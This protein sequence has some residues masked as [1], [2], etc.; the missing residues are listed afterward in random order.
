MSRQS[1]V[2]Y[3]QLYCIILR[4]LSH[5]C[6]CAGL[7]GHRKVERVRRGEEGRNV[8]DIMKWYLLS[9]CTKRNPHVVVLKHTV[10]GKMNVAQLRPFYFWISGSQSHK[11][12]KVFDV[13]GHF[14][15]FFFFAF[16]INSTFSFPQ[17]C[18]VGSHGSNFDV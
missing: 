12:F 18:N 17:C 11:S 6:F 14:F 8:L 2:L 5:S 9:A 15:F 1:T 13:L 3:T 16:A 10:G 4:T 7:H